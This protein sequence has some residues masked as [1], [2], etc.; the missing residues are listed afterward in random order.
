VSDEI[1]ALRAELAQRTEATRKLINGYHE[2][3]AALRAEVER[4]DRKHGDIV[5]AFNEVNQRAKRYRKA[6][7]DAPHVI[8]C[9]A[10]VIWPSDACGPCDCWKA[11]ALAGEE[12]KS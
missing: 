7:E 6:L 2:Q 3:E 4:L 11:R 12:E 5:T 1:D 8:G 9:R 10:R